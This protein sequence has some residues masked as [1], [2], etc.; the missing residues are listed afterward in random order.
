MDVVGF[1]IPLWLIFLIAIIVIFVAWKLI[2]FALKFALVLALFFII[3]MAVDYFQVINKIEG[4]IGL[5]S[6]YPLY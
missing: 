1:P 3:L 2:K 6:S 4:L 5:I